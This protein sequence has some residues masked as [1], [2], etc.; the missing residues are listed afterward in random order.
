[1]KLRM[2]VKNVGLCI[3]TSLAA[4]YDKIASLYS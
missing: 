2:R 4:R 3:N 1:M